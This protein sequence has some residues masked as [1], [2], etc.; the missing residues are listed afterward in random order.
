MTYHQRIEF[1]KRYPFDAN[2]IK[3]FGQ[4]IIT[5]AQDGGHFSKI[6]SGGWKMYGD[7]SSL[8]SLLGMEGND[9]MGENG[10]SYFPAIYNNVIYGGGE[11]E[12]PLSEALPLIE[13]DL[14]GDPLPPELQGVVLVIN[15]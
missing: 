13:W 10:I 12:P 11:N 5:I 9:V 15:P 3:L 7:P 2:F 4:R 6:N 1:L 8:D 14:K